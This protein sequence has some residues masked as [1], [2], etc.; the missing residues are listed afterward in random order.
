V[1]EA[2]LRESL[3]MHGRSLFERGYVCGSAG[4]LSVR[5]PDGV[6]MTPTN[7][8]LGKLQADSISKLD[9]SGRLL[10]GDRPS[11][12]APLHLAVYRSRPQ[13]AAVVHLHSRHATA[14]ACLS[15]IN[16]ADALPA[17]TPY[18]VM[19][20][21]RLPLV[22]YF[23]PGD[24]A[25]TQAVG[26]AAAEAHALL[27]ANHG[28]VVSA[29]DLEAAV[30]ITEELEEAAALHLLTMAHGTRRLTPEQCAVLRQR[31]SQ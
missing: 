13:D 8:C 22:P 15:K 23:P 9:F 31:L 10:S 21:G 2:D 7:S 24:A 25:L 5:L 3:V 27:L 18:Y 16:A 19:R 6:L 12:E 14:V 17:L 28:M 20:V 1:K 30:S 26:T 11:K 29:H 4:N